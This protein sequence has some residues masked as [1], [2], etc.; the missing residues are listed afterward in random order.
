MLSE[1]LARRVSIYTDI[2]IQTQWF[3]TPEVVCLLGY[4]GWCEFLVFGKSGR[5]KVFQ[6][7]CFPEHFCESAVV[8]LEAVVDAE[9]FIFFG[10]AWCGG[11]GEGGEE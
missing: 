4:L 7:G 10:F 2:R 6:G 9:G 11:E 1:E 3:S 5:D 8:D